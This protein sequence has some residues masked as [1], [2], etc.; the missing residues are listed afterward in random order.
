MTQVH[1]GWVTAIRKIPWSKCDN[2]S[3]LSNFDAIVKIKKNADCWQK[4]KRKAEAAKDE[5]RGILQSLKLFTI[6][7]CDKYFLE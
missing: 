1:V 4:E 5:K 3:E 6:D 7:I 2:S